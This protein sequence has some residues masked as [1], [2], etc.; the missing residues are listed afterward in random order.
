MAKEKIT[1]PKSLNATLYIT[2]GVG[3]YNFNRMR[4]EDFISTGMEGYEEVLLKQQEITIDLSGISMDENA[5]KEK[6]VTLLKE[7]QEQ[8]KA[9]SHMKIKDIQEKID[10][11]RAIEYQPNAE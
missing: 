6:I 2:I 8:I 1:I 11:L 3:K 10:Q 9:D 5:V 4:V 7:R